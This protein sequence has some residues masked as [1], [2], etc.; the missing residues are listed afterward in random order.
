VASAIAQIDNSIIWGNGSSEV[1]VGA[2]AT[3]SVSTSIVEGGFDGDGNID[4]DPQFVDP[5][6]PDGVIGTADDD[7][8]LLSTSPALSAADITVLPMDEYDLDEDG[9]TDELIP[10]DLAG[11]SRIFGGWLDIGAYEV[12]VGL[13]QP[14]TYSATGEDPCDPCPAD[15][16]QPDTGASECVACD[17]DDSDTSTID[18]CDAVTGSCRN[19]E[20]AIPAASTWS[21]IFLALLLMS[22]ATIL[23]PRAVGRVPYRRVKPGLPWDREP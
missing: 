11:G 6:G 7:L 18:S 4:A 14:G 1:A 17:C 19:Q 20:I 5:A 21:L 2:D 12:P 8:Q 9:I 23:M 10:L 22:A 16:F 15:T 13:C 3:L